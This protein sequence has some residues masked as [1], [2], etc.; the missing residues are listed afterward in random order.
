MKWVEW[1]IEVTEEDII[2]ATRALSRGKVYES[3]CDCPVS[4]AIRRTMNLPRGCTVTSWGHL[5]LTTDPESAELGMEFLLPPEA[6]HAAE[7]WDKL[8]RLES[9]P[10]FSVWIPDQW[11][12]PEAIVSIS[13]DFM[14]R[15]GLVH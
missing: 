4:F 3:Y 7:E 14:A 8:G 10:K 13:K 6:V 12:S 2:S 9:L 11:A 1:K 5:L 15:G